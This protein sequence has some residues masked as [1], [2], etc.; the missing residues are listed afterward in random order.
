MG[1]NVGLLLDF[2][3]PWGR[4]SLRSDYG[5]GE[6]LVVGNEVEGRS[7]REDANSHKDRDRQDNG[8]TALA[9]CRQ[10]RAGTGY[11]GTRE[12]FK[13]LIP[14]YGIEEN[15]MSK[16]SS[17]FVLQPE[18]YASREITIGEANGGS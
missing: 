11:G 18:Q 4:A 15:G 12:C 2:W 13:I 5:N 3:R 16:S 9:D 14:R 1:G 8:K 17:T 10:H 6:L 7:G